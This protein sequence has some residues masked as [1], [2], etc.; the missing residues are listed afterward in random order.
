MLLGT[1]VGKRCCSPEGWGLWAGQSWRVEPEGEEGREGGRERESE[2]GREE[3]RE[4][5]REE[6]REGGRDARREET[7]KRKEKYEVKVWE[8]GK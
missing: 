3:G 6:G 5:G 1:A 2:G 7:W 4:G 8:K